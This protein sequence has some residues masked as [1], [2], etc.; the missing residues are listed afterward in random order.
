MKVLIAAD[1]SSLNSSISKRFAHANYYLIVD[2]TTMDF[3]VVKNS[4]LSHN[5]EEI[6]T[7]V[8][9]GIEIFIVGNIGPNAFNTITSLNK[10]VALS[11]KSTVLEALKKLKMMELE[12][13]SSPTLKRSIHDHR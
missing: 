7:M 2:T 4:G 5:H 8:E 11:R 12:I 6:S 1:G 9:K 13:L 3:Q 10:K